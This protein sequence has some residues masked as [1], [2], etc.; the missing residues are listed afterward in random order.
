L[1]AKQLSG[2]PFKS[3]EIQDEIRQSVMDYFCDDGTINSDAESDGSSD[4]GEIE[5]QPT[6]GTSASVLQPLT[7]EEIGERSVFYVGIHNLGDKG[8]LV[9]CTRNNTRKKDCIA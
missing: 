5:A 3:L 9:Y 4:E 2:L 7:Y 6:A 1:T 8:L